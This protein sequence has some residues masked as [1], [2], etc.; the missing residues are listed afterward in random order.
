MPAES[1]RLGQHVLGQYDNHS[2]SRGRFPGGR[3]CNYRGNAA[4]RTLHSPCQPGSRSN[5]RTR[6]A[7]I[8]GSLV[9][10]GRTERFRGITGYLFRPEDLRKYRPV[11]DLTASPEG[12][13]S[14]NEAAAL[15]GIRTNVIRGLT[16][17]GLLTASNDFRNGFA[18]LIPAEEVQ[19]FAE[20]YVSTSVLA[21][22]FQLNSG[23]FGVISGSRAHRCLRSEYLMLE[24]ATHFFSGRMLQLRYSFRAAGC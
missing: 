16:N 22:R 2:P 8:H 21:K 5:L 4:A 7:V 6:K 10:T 13:L 23:S 15:L 9:P 20:R 1:P 24:R 3:P 18:R 12:F 17:Q 19:Q 11:P 14:F